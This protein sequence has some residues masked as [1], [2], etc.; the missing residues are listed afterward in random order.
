MA[1]RKII[2]ATV[3][4]ALGVIMSPARAETRQYDW[5]TI[6]E[7]SGELIVETGEDGAVSIAFSFN[8]RGR[9]PDIEADYVIGDGGAPVSIA[10]TGL[11]YTKGD[12]SETFS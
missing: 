1:I 9:G 12:A 3:M 5:L 4:L 7:P 11:T 2:F 8:D 6:G 10:I